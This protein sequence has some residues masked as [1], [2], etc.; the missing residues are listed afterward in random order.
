MSSVITSVNTSRIIRWKD[1]VVAKERTNIFDILWE[2]LKEK[3]RLGQLVLDK[4][5]TLQ[6]ILEK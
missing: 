6:W 2:N 5:I 3:Y 1:H 4:R